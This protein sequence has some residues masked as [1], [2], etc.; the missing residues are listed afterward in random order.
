MPAGGAALK[1]TEIANLVKWVR[2][3]AYWPDAIASTQAKAKFFEDNIRPLIA[4]QCFNCHTTTKS[5]GLQLDTREAMLKGGKSGPAIVPGDPE[6][7]L[8]IAAVRHT[9]PSLMMPKN[10]SALTA[11]Q[12]ADLTKWVQDGAVWTE[13]AKE[14]PFSMSEAQRNLWSIQSLQKKEPPKAKDAAWPVNDIDRFIAAKLEA[15]G[16]KPAPVASRRALLRRA[17][18]DLTGLPPTYEEVQAF[19]ADKSPKAWEKVIDRL[20]ASPRYGEK[21]ARHWMDV[22]R[23]GEDDY[24]VS[25]KDRAELYKF[26]YTYRDWLIKSFNEDMPYDVFVR[27]QLAGD[28][29]AETLRE[30]AAPGLGMNGLGVWHMTNMAPQIERADDLADKVDVTTKAFLGLTVACARCH[31]HKYDAIPTKDFYSIASVFASSPYKAYPLVDKA[32]VEVYDKKKKELDDKEAELKELIRKATELESSLL[33]LQTENYMVAAWKVGSEKN[34]T[35]ESVANQSKLDAEL[36]A[37]WVRFLKRPPV[38]YSFLKKWQAM[39]ERG[40]TLEEAKAEARAFY[41]L[42][43]GIEKENAKIKRDNEI[44]LAK[45]TDPDA[46]EMFEPLPNDKKRII[47]K[48]FLFDLKGIEQERGQLWTDM[49]DYELPDPTKVGDGAGAFGYKGPPGLLK[50]VDFALQKRLPAD[51]AAQIDR[52]KEENEVLKKDLGD[53]Y[54]FAY[55]LGE[56]EQPVDLRVFVRGNPDVFGDPAP[57]SFLAMLSDG[58]A[59]PFTQ[60]S[61]RLQLAEEILKQPIASRVIVNRIWAWL[62]GSGLAATPNN[63]GIAGSQP[64]NPDLLDYLALKFRADGMSIKRLEKDI[65]LTRTYQLSAETGGTEIGAANAA[66]DPDNRFYWKSN[67]RRLDAEGVWDYLLTA[68]GKLDLSKLG[69]PSQELAE[70]MTRRGVYG[71]SSRMF[72][73]AFQLTFDFLTPTISIERRYTTTIPQQ[74]LFFLNS[75]MVHNQAEAMAD[76]IGTAGNEESHVIK[77][78]QI[79]FQRA[80][81]QPELTASL[82]FMHSPELL[83]AQEKTMAEK[84]TPASAAT[85]AAKSATSAMDGAA[86]ADKVAARAPQDSPMKS[87]CWALLSAAEF[88]YI[89]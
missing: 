50:F 4:F 2:D 37:R 13:S 87:L 24:N 71:I 16:L 65:M 6:K 7:S 25:G 53:H 23:F 8:L 12:V 39:V 33:F 26:A 73:N 36:L 63:F 88:L 45:I 57:R 69:G 22:V 19:E 62:M 75:P 70:G 89:N 76:R 44:Q 3:G 60:G 18:Y 72:P 68:S 85:F 74:R 31:D 27:S 5:G 29:L 52:M 42:V 83:R 46:K 32:T 81:S 34:A 58:T 77:A 64:S 48:G 56:S 84:V 43:Q 30:K 82:E 54:P 51:W 41:Q 21:W 38:N 61:G 47:N 49:F 86:P 28:L 11:S 78:F 67:T 10:G 14:K 66:K 9:N 15:E 79:A 17:T 1:N 80:P 35:V 59:K 55:G 40:G 20:Q